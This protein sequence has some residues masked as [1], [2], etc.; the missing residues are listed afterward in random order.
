MPRSRSNREKSSSTSSSKR[1]TMVT[2]E[3]QTNENDFC[4]CFVPKYV[5][6]DDE[7]LELDH[8]ISADLNQI[9]TEEEKCFIRNFEMIPKH[10]VRQ[11]WRRSGKL[12]LKLTL[13]LDLL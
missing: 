12:F 11:R 6:K 4:L 7:N 13:S 9:N 1:V 5:C 2:V 3:T 8:R 10:S